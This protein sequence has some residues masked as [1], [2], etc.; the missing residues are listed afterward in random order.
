MGE[1]ASEGENLATLPF[2]CLGG[3]FLGGVIGVEF[4]D[5]FDA[6][7]VSEHS[8]VGGPGGVADGAFDGA[9][10]GEAVEYFV[11][12]GAGVC[13]DQDFGAVFVFVGA[14]H[15]FGNVVGEEGV[16]FADG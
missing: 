7:F 16:V 5:P 9:A 12:F 15:E 11:G 6:V 13:V 2:L 10:G 14:A 8:G 3:R 1:S 4:Y